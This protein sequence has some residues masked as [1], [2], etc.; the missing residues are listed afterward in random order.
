MKSIRVFDEHTE[1]TV[2]AR[3]ALL[4]GNKKNQ[5]QNA[6]SSEY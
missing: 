3:E 5:Q 4:H 1:L 6:A 2:L